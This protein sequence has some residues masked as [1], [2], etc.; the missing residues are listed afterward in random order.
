MGRFIRIK[1]TLIDKSDILMICYNEEYKEHEDYELIV[2]L[3]NAEDLTFDFIREDWLNEAIDDLENE[4]KEP[5][6]CNI[7]QITTGTYINIDKISTFNRVVRFDNK[8]KPINIIK[9]T[10]KDKVVLPKHFII[11]GDLSIAEKILNLIQERG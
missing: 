4:F 10:W 11:D 8:N 6:N 1:D 2:I 3:Q 7:I 9:V 5:S